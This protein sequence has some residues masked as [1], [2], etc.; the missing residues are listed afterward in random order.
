MISSLQEQLQNKKGVFYGRVSSEEQDLQMQIDS[1]KAFRERH[2]CDV[3]IDRDQ[4]VEKRSATRIPLTKRDAL[5]RVI[6]AVTDKEFDFIVVYNHDRLARDPLEHLRLRKWFTELQ[7]PV[8][9]SSS[10]QVYSNK[11]ILSNAIRDNYSKIEA[12]NIRVRMK[13]SIYSRV[14]FQRKWTGGKTPYG[15]KYNFDALLDKKVLQFEPDKIPVIKEIFELYRNGVGFSSIAVYLSEQ[16]LDPGQTWSKD[17][18]KS[19]ITNPIYCGYLSLHKRKKKSRNSTNNREDWIMEQYHELD[20][21]ISLV[22]WEYCYDLYQQKKTRE[23]ADPMH[24]ST[25]YLFKGIIRCKSCGELLKTK[26][27]SSGQYGDQIYYCGNSS[28]CKIRIVSNV[29][30]KYL[31]KYVKDSKILNIE[32]PVQ[33]E[34]LIVK[35]QNY[36]KEKKH[37]L[38]IDNKSLQH[39]LNELRHDYDTTQDEIKP[40]LLT[41]SDNVAINVLQTFLALITSNITETQLKLKRNIEECKSL[42]TLELNSEHWVQF[43]KD[44]LPI[45]KD[46]IQPLRKLLLLIFEKIEIDSDGGIFITNRIDLNNR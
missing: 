38:E 4:Y 3:I 40:L 1:C 14:V 2:H 11:D 19:I 34:L 37:M 41:Q 8:Y 32:N 45:Q 31:L 42:D 29:L 25:S 30:D 33:R 44:T 27:Q 13:D 16:K 36:Y 24:F 17:R 6:K 23:I 21:I 15:V 12:D 43:F 26:N 28:S 5:M 9:L 46:Y 39:K 22:E 20:P 35:I 7:V 10:N 18:V